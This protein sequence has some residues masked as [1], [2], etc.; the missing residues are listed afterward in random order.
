MRRTGRGAMCLVCLL[1]TVSADAQ[2]EAIL[3]G[4]ITDPDGDPVADANVY[5]SGRVSRQSQ[6]TST[7]LDGTYSLSLVPDMALA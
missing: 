7:G 5:A 6:Q 2:E 3:S 4:Q 1:T